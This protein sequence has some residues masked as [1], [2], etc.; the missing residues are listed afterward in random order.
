MRLLKSRSILVVI[1]SILGVAA[2]AGEDGKCHAP[3]G[4]CERM[5]RQMLA[6]RRYLG[7]EIADLRP[8]VTIK[9]VIPNGPG[10]RARLKAGDRLISINGKSVVRAS[11]GDVKAILAATA[12]TGMVWMIVQRDG[13]FAK[14]ETQLEPY[15]KAYVEKVIA[16]HLS[17]SHTATAGAQP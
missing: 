2:F 1:A 7:I 6:G 9:K 11:A 15:P 16:N 14:I 13:A 17:Q 12:P 5:I 4:E 10:F 8:G 3:T